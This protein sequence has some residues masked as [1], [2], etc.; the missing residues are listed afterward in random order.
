MC[1]IHRYAALQVWQKR[2]RKEIETNHKWR[3][4][5]RGKSPYNGQG[6]IYFHRWKTTYLP[7][8]DV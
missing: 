8:N 4:I 5:E 7:Q 6:Y 2:I 3:G 1:S